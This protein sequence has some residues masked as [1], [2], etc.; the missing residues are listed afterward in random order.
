ML[1]NNKY[2]RIVGLI[3]VSKIKDCPQST[4]IQQVYSISIKHLSRCFGKVAQVKH[5]VIVD[6]QIHME[7]FI[8]HC[9]KLNHRR[10]KKHTLKIEYFLGCKIASM[11]QIDY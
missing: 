10:G 4:P 7:S 6:I 11:Y 8:V 1:V 9:T 2:F 3:F 5:K